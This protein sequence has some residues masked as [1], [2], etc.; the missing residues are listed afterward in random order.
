[1]FEA[2]NS[3]AGSY[4]YTSPAILPLFNREAIVQNMYPILM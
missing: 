4:Y 1:M 2:K 3:R